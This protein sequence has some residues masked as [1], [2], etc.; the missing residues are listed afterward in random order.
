MTYYKR[1]KNNDEGRRGLKVILWRLAERE[2][3]QLRHE[4]QV[5]F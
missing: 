5:I 2:N 1:L 3:N 4:K